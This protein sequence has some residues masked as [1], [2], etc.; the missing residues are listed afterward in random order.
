MENTFINE[1][2]N[3]NKQINIEYR[4]SKKPEFIKR[5]IT[6]RRRDK[7]KR[8]VESIRSHVC[9]PS[10]LLGG[11]IKEINANYSTYQHCIGISTVYDNSNL[12]MANFKF[13]VFDHDLFVTVG[14]EKDD[15]SSFIIR[16]LYSLQGQTIF[17]F[18]DENISF[19]E[20][21]KR[22]ASEEYPY[23]SHVVN[24][25]LRD[26][27]ARFIREDIYNYLMDTIRRSERI[28]EK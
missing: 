4:T 10:V 12:L 13:N 3:I 20:D 1:I 23:K 6:K 22:Y 8:T 15:Y 24:D 17:S 2:I 21:N 7:L 27:F 25:V 5:F 28:G 19:L 11:Y 9:L 26:Y 16:Y 14:P 18:T